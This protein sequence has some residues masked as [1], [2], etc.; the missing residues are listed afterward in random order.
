MCVTLLSAIPALPVR[1]TAV[2]ALFYQ[3]RLGFALL[4]VE[5]GFAI[6]QRDAVEIHLWQA[7]SPDTPGAE[8]HLAGSASCRVR[9]TDIQAL[10]AELQQQDVLH[11]NGALATQHWGVVDFTILD[12]D[13]NAI[14]FNETTAL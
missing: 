10:Y 7:N 14:A 5:D 11:P 13:G 6:V 1:D 12:S 3:E 4:H 2:A 8:P 9:V